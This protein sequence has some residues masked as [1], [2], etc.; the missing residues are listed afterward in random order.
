MIVYANPNKE[1]ERAYG[2]WLR[3]LTRN[4]RNKNIG[5][6]WLRNGSEDGGVWTSTAG[7]SNSTMAMYGGEMVRANFMD[8]NN[9]N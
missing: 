8:N 3:A 4:A 5:A 1:F 7:G 6:R 2:V 9:L